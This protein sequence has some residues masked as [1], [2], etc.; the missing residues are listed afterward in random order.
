LFLGSGDQALCVDP[1]LPMAVNRAYEL[2]A[3]AITDVLSKLSKLNAFETLKCGFVLSTP[4]AVGRR[5]RRWSVK[6]GRTG[7]VLAD[8]SAR[9]SLKVMAFNQ[10]LG[11]YGLKIISEL[12]ACMDAFLRDRHPA[13]VMDHRTRRF[14]CERHR[15]AH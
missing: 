9:S 13:V 14:A 6:C 11:Q 15:A 1:E 12:E 7:I 4:F 3:A 2:H 10:Q 5:S 8:Q